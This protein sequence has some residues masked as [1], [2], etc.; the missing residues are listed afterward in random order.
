MSSATDKEEEEENPF[1]RPHHTIKMHLDSSNPDILPSTMEEPVK[2]IFES[3]AALEIDDDDLAEGRIEEEEEGELDDQF[4]EG[5]LLPNYEADDLERIQ[6]L[7]DDKMLRQC[8]DY[9]RDTVELPNKLSALQL[10]YEVQI[11]LRHQSL[12]RVSA[13]HRFPPVAS[14]LRKSESTNHGGKDSIFGAPP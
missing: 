7:Q 9:I 6:Y 10:P 11:F 4:L 3:V 2:E 1:F 12:F 8:C 5:M 13:R 14:S